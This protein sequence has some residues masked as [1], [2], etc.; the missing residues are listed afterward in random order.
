MYHDLFQRLTLHELEKYASE[1]E[2]ATEEHARWMAEINRTLFCKLPPV[3]CD[4]NQ[5][6]DHLCKFGRWY[7]SINNPVL[8]TLDSFIAIEPAHQQMH[9]AA[10]ELLLKS[11]NNKQCSTAD[12]DG[13][14]AL[15]GTLRLKLSELLRELNENRNLVTRLMCTVFEN[16]AEGVIITAPDTTIVSVNA[17]F[18]EVTGYTEDEVIGKRPSMLRSERQDKTFYAHMWHEIKQF[19]QWQGDIWNRNRQGEDYLERLSIAAVDDDKGEISH[20]VGIFS[21]IT[22]EKESEERLLYL[23]HYDQ[24]TRLPNRLL[25]NDRLQQAIAQAERNK[26]EVA[27]MFLDLDGFKSINDTLGHNSG[28]DLLRQVA[29]RLTACL[30]A[31]D[32]VARFGGDEF[33]IVIASIEDRDDVIRVA[34]KITR[35]IAKP[36][37]ID[38]TA[39]SITTSIGISFYPND[40]KE[41]SVLIHRADNAMYHAKRHGKNH[42]EFYGAI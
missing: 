28:D 16:A 12:Y 3:E 9:L 32:T 27:V 17:A 39:A 34:Q 31:T 35:E 41:P 25:F 42:H 2:L 20:Y 33:T 4:I 26:M 21:D 22:A 15:A 6:P 30:R 11:K 40:G 23:A 18:S 14:I 1:L 36:Y 37:D 13:L 19:G 5:Q 29:Q 10:K 38:G 7:H 24:L 8:T